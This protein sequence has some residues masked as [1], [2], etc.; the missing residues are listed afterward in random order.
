MSESEMKTVL[1]HAAYSGGIAILIRVILFFANYHSTNI[2]DEIKL[3][4]IIV[5][6]SLFF[7]LLILFIRIRSPISS[8]I[9]IDTIINKKFRKQFY[10]FIESDLDILYHVLLDA[11]SK[12]GSSLDV[13][14]VNTLTHICFELGESIYDGTDSNVPSK[15]YSLYPAYLEAHEKNINSKKNIPGSRILIIKREDL[16]ND[17]MNNYET[18]VK[19]VAWHVKNGVSLKVIEPSE[20]IN[21]SKKI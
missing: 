7:V 6:I 21:I 1:Q 13:N 11:P 17:F 10:K 5:L 4:L 15:Y 18:A 9:K 2:L 20:A 16:I 19:F 12:G 8:L 3:D 14:N